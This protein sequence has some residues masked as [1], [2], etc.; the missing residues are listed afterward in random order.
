META[1]IYELIGYLA[2]ILVAVSLMM[3]RIVPLRVVNMIGAATFAVYG[4]LIGSWP[5]AGMNAF[6][7]LIN[8][9][10][11]VQIF[12]SREYLRILE[13]SS[14]DGY[15]N[16]FLDFYEDEIKKFQPGFR[17]ESGEDRLNLLV[18]RNT[19]PAGAIIGKRVN[20]TLSLDLDFVTPAYRDFKI[21][22]FVYREN[23]QFFR[24]RGIR[25]IEAVTTDSTYARKLGQMGFS[26]LGQSPGYR[27]KLDI[28]QA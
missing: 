6:I 4:Y 7:V 14:E 5:V 3:S 22:D 13:V 23:L 8:I 15:L 2:S 26:L 24:Q 18:L 20:D 11:L 28:K 19:V 1:F 25:E 21:A 9:Y 12:R 10:Y 16:Y 27:L 17:T